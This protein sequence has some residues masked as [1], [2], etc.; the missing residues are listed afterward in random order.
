M[1]TVEVNFGVNK[2]SELDDQVN[3][4]DLLLGSWRM[5]GQILGRE[6]PIAHTNEA[7]SV[8]IKIPEEYSLSPK[9][10]NKYVNKYF[11]EIEDRFSVPLISVL[12]KEPRCSNICRCSA[13]KS[14][15]LFTTYLALECPLYCGECFG[16][17]P[18]YRIPKTYDDEYYNIICWMSDYQSC[19]SLQMNCAVGERFGTNQISK[20]DS[21]LTRLGL[22]V[23]DS[24]KEVTDKKT[25]YY[26]YKGSCKSYTQELSRKCPGCNGEWRLESALHDLF[27][28]KCE[29]CSLLSNIAW[30]CRG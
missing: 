11:K 27:N 21:P 8:F 20:L 28:F 24:I 5:N 17:V 10:N 9:F 4:I 14:Y 22:K 12:G 18:L 19:D 30:N 29:K 2:T 16:V 26:L 15:I 7:I 6:H 23:C 13:S 1:Y 3:L 25:Y